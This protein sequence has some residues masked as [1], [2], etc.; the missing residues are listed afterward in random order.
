MESRPSKA[1]LSYLTDGFPFP[2]IDRQNRQ[3]G[4]G[5]N[6]LA[7]RLERNSYIYRQKASAN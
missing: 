1:R 6:R 2:G 5:K 3:V 4:I 7:I